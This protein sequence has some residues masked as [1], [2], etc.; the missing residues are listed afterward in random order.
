M[1]FDVIQ[2]SDS[3]FSLDLMLQTCVC[4]TVFSQS[5]GTNLVGILFF[6]KDL[7]V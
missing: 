2:L 1:L 5:L 7:G 4:M 6:K 3:I